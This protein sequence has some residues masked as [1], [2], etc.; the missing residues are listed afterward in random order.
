MSKSLVPSI[1]LCVGLA[2]CGTGGNDP[3]PGKA[4]EP[5]PASLSI[6]PATV[7]FSHTAEV[8]VRYEAGDTGARASA[9][10]F[11]VEADEGA[12]LLDAVRGASARDAGKALSARARD[13]GSLRVLIVGTDAAEL[14]DGEVAVLHVRAVSSGALGMRLRT[15]TASDAGGGAIELAAMPGELEVTP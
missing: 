6:S 9:I 15:V 3:V 13:D 14:V 1:L 4:T 11:D 10:A 7:R 5:R 8:A 12:V 2:A